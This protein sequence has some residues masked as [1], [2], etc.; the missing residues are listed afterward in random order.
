MLKKE[1]DTPATTT[2]LQN[3]A[4]VISKKFKSHGT[5]SKIPVPLFNPKAPNALVLYDPPSQ[6]DEKYLSFFFF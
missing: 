6:I 5:S 4:S 3:S 2:V 1:E